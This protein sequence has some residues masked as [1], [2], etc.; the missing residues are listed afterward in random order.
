MKIQNLMLIMFFLLLTS[1]Q[2]GAET[3]NWNISGSGLWSE[4]AKWSPVKLPNSR[5]DVFINNSGP[6][7]ITV[8]T[9]AAITTLTVG[10]AK[11]ITLS[12]GKLTLSQRPA[13]L[14]NAGLYVQ[15]EQRDWP[16]G[17]YPGDML[18]TFNDYDSSM[19]STVSVDIGLQ[20]D[21]MKEMGVNTITF[22]LRSADNTTNPQPYPSCQVHKALG[23]LYPQPTATEMANLLLFFDMVQSKGMKV[24]LSLINMH[25]EELPRT[26]SE[27]WL[28]AILGAIG[29]HPALDLVL[30]DGSAKVNSYD[31]TCG[32]Q[33]EAPLW[34]G[35]GSVPA[36]YVQ[37]AIGFA[38]DLGIPARKLSAEAV[39][40]DYFLESMPP[41]GDT[42]TDNH[43]WS[44][45]AV[46]KTIFDNLNIPAS[47]R[48]YAL[49]FYEHKK[50]STAGGLACTD[51]NPHDWADQTL[52][53]V[54]GVVGSGPRIVA[55]EMGD[56]QPVDQVN[57]KTQH[58]LE[59]I[60]F[61]MQKYGMDG[62]AFWR[63]VNFQNSEETDTT[64]ADP[65]KR[66]GLSYI[67]NPVQKE[68]VDMCGI[69]VPVVNGSFEGATVSGVPASWTAAGNGTVA[70]YLLTAE[71]GQPE[72][73][74][75]G[76]H[77]MRIT[78]GTGSTD[79]ITATSTMI[80]VVAATAYTTTAN[81][82]FAWTGDPNPTGSDE[83]RP[84]VFINILYF[85]ANGTPSAVKTNDSF[86]FFQGD[87]T[88]GFATYPQQYTTPGDAAF[89]EIQFG[90]MRNGLPTQITLDVDNV[91]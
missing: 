63:W 88:T 77:T 76:T 15:F 70:Q 56:M 53:Y 78:T 54:T 22:Q 38:M 30:F 23:P 47:D 60:V 33:A 25:M 5:D 8:D 36:V 17:Y 12:T 29:D 44:P 71:T 55:T 11:K 41:A 62:G 82:R 61:L 91:R 18:R 37:W 2:A 85:Q 59:S 52:Q 64:L 24:W 3:V 9:T 26:N 86:S 20:L 43:L 84:Q 74:S 7:T 16:N 69:H 10:G 42:A 66:R 48:T 51:L 35:P 65:V 87:S 80:P 19:G 73:P 45:I 28:G 79:T 14:K 75:R 50:C 39:I 21:K 58:A 89:V 90:A 46:E 13:S 34:L 32:I 1:A 27:T 57:W 67:Y 68:I 31:S 81:M 72:V 40:G 4:S 83:S 6:G 49:S